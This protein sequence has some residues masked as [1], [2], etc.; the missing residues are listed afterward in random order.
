MSFT[1]NQLL[2]GES[3]VLIAHQHALVLLKPILVNVVAAMVLVGISA[4][5]GIS[6]VLNNYPFLLFYLV[7]LAYLCW[8]ISV[9]KNREYV[10]T[11][12]RVV[13]QEGVV[14][15]SSFDAPLDKINNVFHEQSALG[16]IL[17]FG[18]VGLETASEQGTTQFRMIAN[19]VAFKN[20]IVQQREA[21]RISSQGSGGSGREDI[22]RL[23]RDLAQLR[24][25]NV[26]TAEEFEVQKRRLL[27][28]L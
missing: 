15:V 17:G 5:L 26:I 24:D 19:P 14:A 16:R 7:P 10:I 18:D 12:R 22:P 13:K 23:L 28:K 21:Y 1:K 2:P 9:R 25:R 20:C 11:N 6:V 4:T 8:E 3:I 27:E